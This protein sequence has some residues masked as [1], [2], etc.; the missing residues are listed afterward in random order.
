VQVTGLTGATQVAAGLRAGFA[1]HV[2]LPVPPVPD[3]TGDTQAQAA[4]VLQAAA[5]VLGAVTKVT[6]KFCAHLGLVISQT[7][8]AG[9]SVFPGSAVSVTI[10][11]A[12]AN[13]CP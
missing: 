5:L 10:G 2:P 8:A 11:Q 9:T 4:Q 1:V 6:D 3:L 7:P 12:P 13:G